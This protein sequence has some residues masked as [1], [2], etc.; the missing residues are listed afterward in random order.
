MEVDEGSDQK[1]DKPFHPPVLMDQSQITEVESHKHLGV[2]FS[3][4]C[5]WHENLELI[6]SKAWKRINVMRK[7]KFE[8]DRKSLQTIYFSFI[9][10]LLEYA[11]VVWNNC[12]QYESNELEKIQNEAA[13]I[14][15]GATKL[16]SI[17]SLLLETGWETLAS[18]RKKHKLTLLF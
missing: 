9:R 8:L 12:A 10:P 7:L 15:T 6:K 13:R 1:S 17:N 18:R 5:T 11:D 2:I 16:V 14:L 4:D 3:N